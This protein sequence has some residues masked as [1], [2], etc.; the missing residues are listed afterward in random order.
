[1]YIFW[2]KAMHAELRLYSMVD[3]LHYQLMSSLTAK[4]DQILDEN[5]TYDPTINFGKGRVVQNLLQYAIE[6]GLHSLPLLFNALPSLVLTNQVRSQIQSAV[7][8]K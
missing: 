5:Q 2:D 8:I 4:V 1:M 7:N 6:N 3:F